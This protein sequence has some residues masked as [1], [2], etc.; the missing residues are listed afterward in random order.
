MSEPVFKFKFMEMINDELVSHK[1]R[2]ASLEAAILAKDAVLKD[3]LSGLNYLRQ[4][5][6]VPYGFGIDRLETT[7]K[8]ALASSDGGDLQK[9]IEGAYEALR[10]A[11]TWRAD[12]HHCAE[13]DKDMVPALDALKPY[14]GGRA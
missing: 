6:S 2:I 8:E 1:S 5:N 4:N 3:M 14:A 10:K 13:K 11:Y 9:A 12:C 7:A